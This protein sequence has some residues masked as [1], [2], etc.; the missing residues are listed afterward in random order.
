MLFHT[1]RLTIRPLAEQD[2]AAVYQHRKDPQTSRYIGKPAT[3]DDAKARIANAAL[4]WQGQEN[5]R[6][7]LAVELTP[8]G[9]FIGEVMFKY[10]NLEGEIGEFGYRLAAEFIG[11]GYGYEVA[12]GL[13]DHLFHVLP[14]HKLT[15]IAAIDNL[16][17][18]K[19]MEKLGMQR[20]GVLR[21]HMKLK[22]GHEDCVLYGILKT[23]WLAR[24]HTPLARL[25]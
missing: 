23:E 4:P 21:S 14:L 17:S 22:N 15:A 5:E 16:A 6:L 12:A 9:T 19:L 8:C 10:I 24:N 13:I 2:L 18:W 11:Q 25:A 20:E 7:M 3:L 1:T